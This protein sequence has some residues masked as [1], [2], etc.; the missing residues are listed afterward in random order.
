MKNV[1][2]GPVPNDQLVI[3]PSFYITMIDLFG[4][5]GSSVPGFEQATRGRRE[6]ESKVH[7]FVAVCVTTRVVNLQALEGK[8]SGSIIEGFTRLCNEVG[9]HTNCLI[10]QDSGAMAGFGPARSTWPWLN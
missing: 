1:S 7:I 5:V 2:M 6:L 8:D 4:P 3:A 10:G 9:T